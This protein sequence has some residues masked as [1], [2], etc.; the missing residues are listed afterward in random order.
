VKDNEGLF[1]IPESKTYVSWSDYIYYYED[2]DREIK[3]D[4]YCHK[5]WAD[6]METAKNKISYKEYI[7]TKWRRKTL[8]YMFNR[9]NGCYG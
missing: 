4:S 8:K 3:F 9:E 2:K 1:Y 6:R 7:E 5:V